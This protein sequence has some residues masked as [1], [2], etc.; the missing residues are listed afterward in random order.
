M[1]DEFELLRERMVTSQIERRGVT[2]P[3]VLKT[4]RSV[5]RHLFVDPL[6]QDQAYSDYPLP[7]GYDQTISQPYIVALMTALLN[8]MGDEKVLEVGTGSGYQAAVLSMLCARVHT[9]ELI[10]QLSDQARELL[11]KL[12]YHNVIVHHSDGS[13][14]WEADAPYDAIMVTASAPHTPAPLLEQLASGGRLVIPV[15]SRGSQWLE[16]WQQEGKTWQPEQILPVAFVPLRG[17]HGWK[18]EDD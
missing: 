14:G 8:L 6:H 13:L 11:G 7:I 2:N 12:G 4:M 3:A 18:N 5:P 16:F 15:G 10:P 1:S 17:R 9:V